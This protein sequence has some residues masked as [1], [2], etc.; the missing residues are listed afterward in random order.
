M[1]GTVTVIGTVPALAGLTATFTTAPPA[2]A[3]MSS[4]TVSAT[5]PP[6]VMVGVA[7]VRLVTTGCSAAPTT[8]TVAGSI[9]APSVAVSVTL[10][11]WARPSTSTGALIWPA[12]IVTPPPTT[13]SAAGS[14]LVTATKVSASAAPD[15]VTVNGVGPVGELVWPTSMNDGDGPNALRIGAPV[16]RSA[17]ERGSSFDAMLRNASTPVIDAKVWPIVG[18]GNR[19]RKSSTTSEPPPGS[20]AV[21][22][23]WAPLIAVIAVAPVRTSTP[24][25]AVARIPPVVTSAAV[26]ITGAGA[27]STA[28]LTTVT[29]LTPSSSIWPLKSV[30]VPVTVTRL[31]GAIAVR[32]GEAA[33]VNTNRPEKLAPW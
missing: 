15:S 16:G 27:A 26:T 1:A 3:G 9:A 10:A 6:G 12:R 20:M 28:A 33:P 25:S 8:R 30:T 31:P 14:E 18:A 22:S 17:A 2:R 23:P 24:S 4:V 19:N 7:G 11:L 5:M 32:N 29:S 13:V 21:N